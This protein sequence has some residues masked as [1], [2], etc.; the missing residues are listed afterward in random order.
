M[1][2]P[3]FLFLWFAKFGCEKLNVSK[4]ITAYFLYPFIYKQRN[5]ELVP[6]KPN[7]ANQFNADALG[8]HACDPYPTTPFLN[9]LSNLSTIL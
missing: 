4:K 5:Q 3:Q 7:K 2:F 8:H 9:L 1:F 6:G